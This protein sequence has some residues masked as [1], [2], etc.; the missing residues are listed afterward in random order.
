[1]KKALF[2]RIALTFH[3]DKHSKLG[4]IP[5]GPDKDVFFVYPLH[6]I[7]PDYSAGLFSFD[8]DSAEFIVRRRFW[9]ESFENFRTPFRSVTQVRGWYATIF[10]GPNSEPKHLEMIFGSNH[11]AEIR[12]RSFFKVNKTR[13]PYEFTANM[14]A[15]MF[16]FY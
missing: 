14:E 13:Y 16:N 12:L 5:D 9:L 7:L 4:I 6:E 10:L 2:N 1:M 8:N 11:K 3:K 15:K